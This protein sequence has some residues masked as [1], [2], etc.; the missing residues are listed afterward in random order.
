V[1]T[2]AHLRLAVRFFREAAGSEPV[3]DWLKSLPAEERSEIGTDIK[4]VQ[5]G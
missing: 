3:R 5:F 1:A 4:T 2:R